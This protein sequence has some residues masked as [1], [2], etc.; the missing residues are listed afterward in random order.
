[1]LTWLQ[2]NWPTVARYGAAALAAIAGGSAAWEKGWLKWL[3]MVNR[4][5]GP[6]AVPDDPVDVAALDLLHVA[7]V[8]R[9]TGREA[10][11]NHT[12]AALTE[13]MR[14]VREESK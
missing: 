13:L 9:E 5:P 3:P 12:V 14:P 11:L 1:M 10:V 6:V 2:E 7:K 8:A 4:K